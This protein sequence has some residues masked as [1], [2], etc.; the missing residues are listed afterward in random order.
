VLVLEAICRAISRARA[1]SVDPPFTDC[2]T[3]RLTIGMNQN[4]Y[5][6]TIVKDEV[7]K[8]LGG[9]TDV[10]GAKSDAATVGT[11]ALR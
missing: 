5:N 3:E 1:L 6:G 10:L 11:N 8:F 9:G 7:A 2:F 4:F